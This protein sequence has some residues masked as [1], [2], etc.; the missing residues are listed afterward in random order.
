MKKIFYIFVNAVIFVPLSAFAQLTRPTDS[1]GLAHNSSVNSVLVGVLYKVLGFIASLAILMIVVSGIM[2][3]IS[4]GDNGK[5]ETAKN[6]L[7]YSVIG[8]VVA[9]LGYV[10]VKTVSGALGAG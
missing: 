7:T 8:L 6:W 1:Y 9:L 5:V 4:G 2:Y 10:I 3:M